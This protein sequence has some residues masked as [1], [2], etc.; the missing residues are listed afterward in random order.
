MM[1]PSRNPLVLSLS[2]TFGLVLSAASASAATYLIDL[3]MSASNN[4]VNQGAP[5][6]GADS[7]GHYWNN[8]TSTNYAEVVLPGGPGS[9]SLSNLVDT[10]NTS[11]SIGIVLNTGSVVW[12]SSGIANGGLDAVIP[13]LGNLAVRTATQDYYFI[14]G[15]NGSNATLTLT[16][17]DP[18]ATYSLG[19]FGTRGDTDEVRN[20]RY[21]I[22]DLNG[23]QQTDIQT[24]GPGTGVNGG[25]D[26]N[27]GNDST[28]VRFENLVPDASGELVLTVSIVNGG[29][30]Y[31]GA[32]ELTEAV[33]EPGSALLGGLGGLL[34]LTRRRRV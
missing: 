19:L 20:T 22:A 12:R 23:T 16:G 27:N 6:L 17:L 34:L 5:T 33:P 21:S 11:S 30:A 7:N 3:G 26:N 14:M 10:S 29:Y 9:T 2:L 24:S 31:L 8:L 1:K 32:I 13:A 15:S 18:A 28:V 4:P 25:F